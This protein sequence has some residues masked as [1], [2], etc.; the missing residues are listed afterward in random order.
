P[1]IGSEVTRAFDEPGIYT[2]RLTVTDDSGAANGSD[3]RE[4]TVAIN[5]QPA[6]DAGPTVMTESSV[7]SFDGTASVDPDGDAL[8]YRWDF[9]DG[10]SGEGAQVQH[11]Y[12]TG[13]TY[14]VIL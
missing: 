1:L 7:I 2:A 3:S 13:G 8:T 11:T 9:G 10:S 12:A 4:I 6:A 14:P 5:H